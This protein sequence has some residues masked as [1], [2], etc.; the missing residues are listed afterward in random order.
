MNACSWRAE[1]CPYL[2]KVALDMIAGSV[3]T[4][5]S[6]DILGISLVK[7]F[8]L[9]CL[10]G[11][12][13]YFPLHGLFRAL[14]FLR[15]FC[16]RLCILQLTASLNWYGAPT[17]SAFPNFTYPRVPIIKKHGKHGAGGLWTPGPATISPVSATLSLA[18][19]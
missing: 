3:G 4:C 2:T 19:Y 13:G 7:C 16:L 12:M 14:E 17:C 1:G 8:C 9:L 10:P 11:G 5:N 15:A 6:A 18:T